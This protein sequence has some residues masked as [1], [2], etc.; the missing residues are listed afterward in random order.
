MGGVGLVVAYAVDRA[1]Q[2]GDRLVLQE[3]N[4][5]AHQRFFVTPHAGGYVLSASHSPLSMVMSALG[6]ARSMT[7]PCLST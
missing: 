6:S 1:R 2:T 4:G 3:P 5:G 7:S